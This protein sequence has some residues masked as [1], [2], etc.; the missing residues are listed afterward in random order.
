MVAIAADE[1]TMF[2]NGKTS[3]DCNT[4]S[5]HRGPGWIFNIIGLRPMRCTCCTTRFTPREA[6]SNSRDG[7]DSSKLERT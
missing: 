6:S 4:E 5:L 2:C 7:P 1:V 3:L